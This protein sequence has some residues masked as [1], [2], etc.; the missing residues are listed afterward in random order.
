MILVELMV[1]SCVFFFCSVLSSASNIGLQLGIREV[2]APT[3][4]DY[5]AAY[6]RTY[7]FSYPLFVCVFWLTQPAKI[8]ISTIEVITAIVA[9]VALTCLVFTDFEDYLYVD[10][11]LSI[12][13]GAFEQPGGPW[14]DTFAI[15]SG[16]W[17]GRLIGQLYRGGRSMLALIAWLVVLIGYLVVGAIARRK[18][19]KTVRSRDSVS[20]SCG[21]C[22]TF[23]AMQGRMEEEERLKRESESKRKEGLRK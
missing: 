21:H 17:C 20:G 11:H 14:S 5:V 18:F 8:P 6:L 16:L 15:L 22:R 23:A 4:R 2:K 10:C 19:W 7:L 13:P 3:R 12:P 1:Y 9:P